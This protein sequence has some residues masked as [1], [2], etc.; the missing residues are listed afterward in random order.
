MNDAPVGNFNMGRTFPGQQTSL[1]SLVDLC[2]ARGAIPII[3]TTPHHNVEMSQTYPTIP[4]GNPLFWPFR[5]YNVTSTYVFDAVANTI[6]QSNFA[7]PNYGGNILKPGHTLR[8]E[9]GDNIGNYTITAISSDRNTITVQETIPVS[10]S[11]S[12]TVRHFNLQSIAEDIL[13]PAP[14]V[15][16]VTKDWSG[17]GVKVQGDVRFEMVNNM[18]RVV[19]RKKARSSQTVKSRSLSMV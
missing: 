16:F 11:Y 10:G 15:S 8:V 13:Y 6:T 7:N 3:C 17:S 9:S 5:T 12:T 18:Q 14:S 19:A 1:E 4:G 2:L